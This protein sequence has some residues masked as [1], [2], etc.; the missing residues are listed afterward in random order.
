M[1]G[2]PDRAPRKGYLPPIPHAQALSLPFFNYG[3]SVKYAMRPFLH[4]KTYWQKSLHL[5]VCED[6]HADN[7]HEEKFP[8]AGRR[9]TYW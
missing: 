3:A 1:A 9:K 8:A 6:S 7:P 4:R 5:T 2:S